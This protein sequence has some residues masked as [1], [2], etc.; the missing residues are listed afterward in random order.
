MKIKR[1]GKVLIA[2]S[3]SIALVSVTIQMWAAPLRETL[4]CEQQLAHSDAALLENFD[5]NYLLFERAAALEKR[6]MSRITFVPVESS[7][8][9]GAPNF[10]SARIAEVMARHAGIENWAMVPITHVEPITLNAALQLRERLTAEHV[11]SVLVLS[12]GFR[13]RRSASV[14]RAAFGVVGIEVRCV[15]VFGRRSPGTWTQT[16]HG[17]Q[18]VLAEFVKLQYYRVY[19]LPFV[20]PKQASDNGAVTAT[21][22]SSSIHSGIVGIDN[23][24]PASSASQMT[25]GVVVALWAALTTS[26][27][28]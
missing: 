4:V 21:A 15:P 2:I 24:S 12:P 22:T 16:W 18:E 13:S 3:M 14:Y 20:A 8:D 11:R 10:V 5:A 7:T 26:G 23:I 1:S 25:N 19:V 17:V 27:R 9:R 28:S 6:G